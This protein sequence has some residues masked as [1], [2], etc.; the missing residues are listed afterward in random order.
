MKNDLES[1]GVQYIRDQTWA[2]DGQC[3]ADAIGQHFSD[4][5]GG[6]KH[7]NWSDFSY[8]LACRWVVLEIST[9]DISKKGL[10][11][12]CAPSVFMCAARAY[13]MQGPT[14]N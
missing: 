6:T 4:S 11:E 1:S 14:E 12:A 9:I 8:D 5:K 3:V 7:Y 13:I 10:Q 2:L